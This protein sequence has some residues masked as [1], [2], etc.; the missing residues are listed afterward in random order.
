MI[1]VFSTWK[2]ASTRTSTFPFYWRNREFQFFWKTSFIL[3]NSSRLK[4]ITNQQNRWNID[5]QDIDIFVE[6]A[7][8]RR[9]LNL[10]CDNEIVEQVR[11][12]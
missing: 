1:W 8:I 2:I 12:R 4:L 11:R 7:V 9:N 3:S 5:S 10:S 6:I